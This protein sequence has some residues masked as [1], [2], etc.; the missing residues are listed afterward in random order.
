MSISMR[1]LGSFSQKGI[2]HQSTCVDTPQQDG[3]SERKKR[4]L[5]EVAWILLFA[6]NLTKQFWGDV[7][8]VAAY[9]INGILSKA[10]DTKTPIGILKQYISHMP[11][12][13]SLP[14]KVFSPTT[15]VHIPIKDWSKLVKPLNVF[16]RLLSQ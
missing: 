1:I 13:G 11:C 5:L 14:P 16:L 3:V 15:L 6:W 2:I 4:H 8:L 9:L 12:L 7:I 10:L